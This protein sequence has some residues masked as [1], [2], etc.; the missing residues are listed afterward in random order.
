MRETRNRGG[1]TL[2]LEVDDGN[3]SALGL[4]RKLGFEKVGERPAYYTA[5]DGRR[6]TAL[7]LRRVLG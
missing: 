6:A 2:F 5:P 3:Q 7:V 4:Y 1:S